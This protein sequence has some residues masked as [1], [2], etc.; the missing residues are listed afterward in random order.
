[1]MNVEIPGEGASCRELIRSLLGLKDIDMRTYVELLGAEGGATA[2]EMGDLLDR[3]RSTAY[4]SLQRLVDCGL[5]EKET[6]TI[7]EGGYFYIYRAVRPAEAR[8]LAERCLNRWYEEIS[9][10][11]ERMEEEFTS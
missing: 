5:A 1:M 8:K 6:R 2:D 4:R 7:E 9:D 3:E 10:A 11:V